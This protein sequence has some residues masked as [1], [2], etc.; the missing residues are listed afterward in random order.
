MTRDGETIREPIVDDQTSP[1]VPMPAP[2]PAAPTP[3]PATVTGG[4][5]SAD[6]P[7]LPRAVPMVADHPPGV[8]MG[9]GNTAGARAAAEVGTG[10]VTDQERSIGNELLAALQAGIADITKQAPEAIA[11]FAEHFAPQIARQALLQGSDDPVVAAR[12]TRHR[13][14]LEAQAIM[15]AGALGVEL[16]QRQEQRMIQTFRTLYAVAVGVA[17]KAL[18]GGIA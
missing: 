4:A 16:Q 15:R 12:A 10:P 6:T 17:K 1:G 7:T 18:T 8:I 14:H 13:E 3:L 11:T 9:T 5:A 2:G